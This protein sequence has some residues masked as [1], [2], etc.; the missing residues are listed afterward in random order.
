MAQ[1]YHKELRKELNPQRVVWEYDYMSSEKINVS[2]WDAGPK[3][4]LGLM[5]A[6]LMAD[7]YE[8]TP[9]M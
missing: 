8:D 4:M 3:I 2:H 9:K 5:S 1:P 6:G 7:G